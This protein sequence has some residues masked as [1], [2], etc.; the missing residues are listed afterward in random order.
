MSKEMT[1]AV[2]GANGNVGNKF[3]NQAL[4]AGYKV[5]AFVRSAS[6]FKHLDNPNVDIVEGDATNYND[7]E[8][9]VAGSDVVVSCLGNVKK[10]HIMYAAHNNILNAA[11]KQSKIPRCILISTI[12]CGGTSWV[13]KQ[14]LT[15]IV[16]KTSIDDYEKADKRI[17]DEKK[18]PFILVRPYALTDKDGKGKYYATKKQKGTFM[19]PIARADVAKFMLDAVSDNQWD[20]GP[21]VLLG[22]VK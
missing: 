7:V 18:V 5:R 3:V 12:G 21:G 10:N 6:K 20:G 16:G 14:L 1:I 4:E 13:V 17:R 11:S 15:S 19:K 2:F 9:A 22:G 8:R